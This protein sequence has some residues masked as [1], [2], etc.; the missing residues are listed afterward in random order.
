MMGAVV[1]AGAFSDVLE[2]LGDVDDAG[3]GDVDPD[4]VSETVWAA[5]VL[6]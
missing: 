4:A 3:G 6:G 2:M 1:A 5:L